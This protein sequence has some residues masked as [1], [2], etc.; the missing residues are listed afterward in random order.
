MQ[1]RHPNGRGFVL[2]DAEV[3]RAAHLSRDS[4]AIERARVRGARLS[5]HST[6]GG[7]AQV[8]GGTFTHAHVGSRVVVA[9]AP[10]VS[11]SIIRCASVS[12]APVINNSVLEE[13][14]EVWDAPVLD[15]VRLTGGV[16]VY[17]TAHLSGFALGG[18][19]RVH[20]GEWTR[21]PLSVNLG[22]C[23]VTEC[24]EGRVLVDC[25]CRVLSTWLKHAG[26]I[27]ARNGMTREQVQLVV[28]LLEQWESLRARHEALTTN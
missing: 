10:E 14:V 12:G 6:A 3:S 4:A 24:V 13:A 1:R 26:A 20:E 8:Y 17:G 23:V 7:D 28:R 27:G 25:S 19:A 9:G 15:R 5:C 16:Y 21:P 18:F 22:F 2:D 11:N